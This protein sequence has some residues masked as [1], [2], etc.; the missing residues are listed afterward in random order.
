MHLRVE[1]VS[2]FWNERDI[3]GVRKVKKTLILNLDPLVQNLSY[4]LPTKGLW[5]WTSWAFNEKNNLS[6]SALAELHIF[7]L[8]FLNAYF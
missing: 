4:F 3:P 2:I 7:V 6:D 8:F 5:T 1:F